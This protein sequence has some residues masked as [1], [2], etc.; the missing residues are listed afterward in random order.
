MA[1]T[2]IE[3]QA[4]ED[5]VGSENITREPAILDTYTQCWGHKV[6]FD[7]KFAPRPAAVL[8]PG[9]TEELQ[10][11]VKLCNRYRISFKPFSSGFENVAFA[12]SNDR[13][14]LLDLKRMDRIIEID[15]KNMHAV[16][17]PYVNLYRL[18]REAMR[19]GL[20]VGAIGAG[21]SAG[22]IAGSCCHFGAGTT[23][24]STGGLGRN[25]LGVE[26][27]LPTGDVLTMGTAEAG[28]GWFSAEGPGPGLRG[29]MRGRSGANGGHGIIS[30]ASVKLYPWYGEADVYFTADAVPG[31]P[32]SGKR[33]SKVPDNYKVFILLFPSQAVMF[34]ALARIGRAEICTVLM[35]AL[36]F[37]YG[38]GND[39]QWALIQQMKAAGIS[40]TAVASQ[41]VGVVIGADTPRG[42]EYREKCLMEIAGQLGG[43]PIPIPPVDQAAFFA[44]ATWHFG[45][46]TA[47]FRRTGD[48]IVF[49]TSD[50]SPDTMLEMRKRAETLMQPYMEQGLFQTLD[51][52][53]MFLLP[54]E[55]SSTGFH[56][57]N[58]TF[59]DPWNP[60]SLKACREMVAQT[61]DPNGP[62][63]SFGVPH[64]GA[65]LQIEWKSHIHQKY[66][67]LYDNYDVWLRQV[68][69]MLD[70][71]NV[72]DWSSYIP[73]VFP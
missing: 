43:G 19:H 17:E 44:A 53:E 13:A 60:D 34:D 10:S 71:N 46:V 52:P 33:L 63:R 67:P 55:H 38:E 9:S 32:P 23:A 28:I 11:I 25:V 4:L 26:W 20:T 12:L 72:A 22:V 15:V 51:P 3:Y 2:D 65:G 42:L 7:E 73:N 56:E 29:V 47:A 49:P 41:G 39:E 69:E 21:P 62:F 30:K 58:V 35:G 14:I 45:F 24:V 5:V 68:R 66:G 31:A 18:Q 64:L 1:L 57:E 48:F 8:L 61:E 70:P 40:F 16:V 50:G 6:V 59:Y 37:P 27:V 36:V 54:S